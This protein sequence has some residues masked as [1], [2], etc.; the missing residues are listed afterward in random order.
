MNKKKKN[1][2]ISS[3]MCRIYGL[4]TLNLVEKY[5]GYVKVR[6]I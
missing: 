4:F 6:F 1:T 2:I 3:T 5:V